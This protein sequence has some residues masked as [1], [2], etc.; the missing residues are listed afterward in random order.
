MSGTIRR[1]LNSVWGRLAWLAW[2]GSLVCLGCGDRPD[3]AVE[4][5]HADGGLWS[6]DGGDTLF[7][8]R[9]DGVRIGG[10]AGAVCPGTV[11]RLFVGRTRESIAV[12]VHNDAR[13]LNLVWY[14][15]GEA[16]WVLRVDLA[17]TDGITVVLP[18]GS[19]LVQTSCPAGVCTATPCELAR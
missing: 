11:A 13:A 7:C 8:T 10:D 6:T 3:L 1:T 5:G 17:M 16:C 9:D 18:G 4:L 15:V 14:K 19:G 2:L 12:R